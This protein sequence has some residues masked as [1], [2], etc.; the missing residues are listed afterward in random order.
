MAKNTICHVEWDVTDLDRA[1]KF[2]AAVFDWTFR[3][4]GDDMVVFGVGD[5]HLGGLMKVDAV[6]AGSSPSVWIE[7]EDVDR[8][9]DKAKAA[10]GSVLKSKSP[11]PNVGWSGQFQDPDGNAVGIVQF[12][13]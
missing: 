13:Q 9:L 6:R 4:F 11:V 10:G 2:Y 5:Q 8:F 3:A 7:V 12:A 1:Q